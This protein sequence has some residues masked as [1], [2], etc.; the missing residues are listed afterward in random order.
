MGKCTAA[1]NAMG[2]SQTGQGVVT[3][4]VEAMCQT[5][6]ETVCISRQVETVCVPTDTGSLLAGPTL[7]KLRFKAWHKINLQTHTY[8]QKNC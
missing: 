4:L 8:T 6:Q 5:L 7:W 2:H 3:D 1:D